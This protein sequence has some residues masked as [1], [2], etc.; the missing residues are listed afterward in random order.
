MLRRRVRANSTSKPTQFGEEEYLKLM[1]RTE[2]QKLAIPKLSIP[3]VEHWWEG[4]VL[5]GLR[6]AAAEKLLFSCNQNSADKNSSYLKVVQS[7]MSNETFL[8]EY[9]QLSIGE[10]KIVFC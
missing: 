5:G 4:L 3:P 1:Q 9:D 2:L 7:L 10:R 6:K 8:L